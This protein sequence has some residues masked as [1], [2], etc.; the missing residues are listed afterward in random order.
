[1]AKVVAGKTSAV[2]GIAGLA[3]AVEP[4]GQRGGRDLQPSQ[5]P[6]GAR[7]DQCGLPRQGI[8][9]QTLAGVVA[10]A[11]HGRQPPRPRQSQSGSWWRSSLRDRLGPLTAEAPAVDYEE[12][13]T[14]TDLPSNTTGVVAMM[15]GFLRPKTLERSPQLCYLDL[16]GWRRG[17]RPPWPRQLR[18]EPRLWPLLRRWPWPLTA[19]AD[20]DREMSGSLAG[21]PWPGECQSKPAQRVG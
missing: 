8:P 5:E 19:K 12:S 4:R 9:A 10:T 15:A 21:Q 6:G 2:V 14:S 13:A 11:G 16:D 18:P 17:R 1:M 3:L 7:G 20:R